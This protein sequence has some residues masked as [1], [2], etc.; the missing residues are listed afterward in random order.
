[1]F[2]NFQQDNWVEL[3]PVVQL[4]YNTV[5]TETT[6]VIP[7]FTNFRFKADLR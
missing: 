6:K 3:L 2:I 5:P 7:F 4:A 1:M